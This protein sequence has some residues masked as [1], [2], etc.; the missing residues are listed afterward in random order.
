[1]K[2]DHSDPISYAI[3]FQLALGTISLIFALMFGKFSLPPL[4]NLTLNFIA[5]SFLWA[6]ATVFGFRAIKTLTAGEVTIITTSSSVISIILSLIFL[7]ESLNS[8]ILTGIILIFASIWLVNNDHLK[9]TSKSGISF[10]LL[11]AACAGTAVVNDAVILHQYEAFSYTA[12]MSF[13]PG[14][15]LMLLFPKKIKHTQVLLNPRSIQLMSIFCLFYS[16][17]AITYYLAFQQGAPV[18]QLSPFT[19][20]SIVLTVILG[21]IFLKER[22]HLIKKIIA[23]ILVTI[24]STFLG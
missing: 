6:G 9:L 5:S 14:V 17:Q 18:S 11:S 21:A 24:G 13:L 23:S 22:Q 2:D 10:A 16:I 20:S 12:I 7:G 1:M 4:H 15:I 19:K 3:V 8:T